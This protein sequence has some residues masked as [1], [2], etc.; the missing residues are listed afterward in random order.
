M[1]RRRLTYLTAVF[2]LL[3]SHTTARKRRFHRHAAAPGNTASA[4]GATDPAVLAAIGKFNCRDQPGGWERAFSQGRWAVA[5]GCLER[6]LSAAT[7]GG[8]RVVE[9]GQPMYSARQLTQAF[10]GE[11]RG[12]RLA[13]GLHYLN[14][15]ASQEGLHLWRAALHDDSSAMGAPPFDT[16]TRRALTLTGATVLKAVGRL[17][18]ANQA[19]SRAFGLEGTDVEVGLEVGEGTTVVPTTRGAVLA[20]LGGDETMATEAMEMLCRVRMELG[21]FQAK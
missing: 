11:V 18:E 14:A 8:D 16:A 13:V 2:L 9:A 4:A 20:A 15:K 10:A 17:H 1:G 6:A 21:V 3:A 19:L 12:N 5:Q 7:H